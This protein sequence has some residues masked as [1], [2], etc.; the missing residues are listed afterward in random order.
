MY[1][2]SSLKN[3]RNFIGQ[4]KR[5]RWK[6]AKNRYSGMQIMIAKTT[7]IRTLYVH[8]VLYGVIFWQIS[9]HCSICSK[10]STCQIFPQVYY[11]LDRWI[12]RVISTSTGIN[13]KDWPVTS[14]KRA[15]WPIMFIAFFETVLGREHSGKISKKFIGNF[16]FWGIT[17]IQ[18]FTCNVHNI[19]FQFKPRFWQFCLV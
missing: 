5:Y 2:L 17:L 7:T 9:W 15:W 14:L 10:I 13:W 12:T 6:R 4:K 19:L 1:I 16:N 8:V 18:N 11:N 3:I